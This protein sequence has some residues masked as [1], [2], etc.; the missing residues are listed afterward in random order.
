MA[1]KRTPPPRHRMLDFIADPFGGRK[2]DTKGVRRVVFGLNARLT[3]LLTLLLLTLLAGAAAV[4]YWAETPAARQSAAELE[5]IGLLPVR[6]LSLF[7]AA[8]AI[9]GGAGL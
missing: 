5:R 8:A 6:W 1:N 3:T 7:V 2:R 9:A 4:I